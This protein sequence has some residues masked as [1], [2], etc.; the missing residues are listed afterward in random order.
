MRSVKRMKCFADRK[1]RGA[2]K[3]EAE[4]VSDRN[5]D[6]ARKLYIWFSCLCVCVCG[7]AKRISQMSDDCNTK[8]LKR[9]NTFCGSF[10][11]LSFFCY[12]CECII[13]KCKYP[14]RRRKKLL[15][16]WENFAHFVSLIQFPER[17]PIRELTLPSSEYLAKHWNELAAVR[18]GCRWLCCYC[19]KCRIT[20]TNARYLIPHSR[21][22]ACIS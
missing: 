18:C 8:A 9:Q 16:F 14:K 5:F 10:S 15:V 4:G 13:I 2:N 3:Y 1:I 6:D 20:N 12:L 7:R 21:W 22:S 11:R 19:W 17:Y